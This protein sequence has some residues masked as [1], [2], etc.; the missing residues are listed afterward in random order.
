M[1]MSG[2]AMRMATRHLRHKADAELNLI[3]MIDIL[4]VLVSFLLIYSTE[5]E[6]VQ[7]TR[8]IEIPES[9]VESKPRETVVVM[10]TKDDLYLQGERIASIAEIRAS[11]EPLIR[12]L[13]EALKQPRVIGTRM[14]E[15]DLAGR[16]V[17]VM[18]DKNTPYEVLKKVMA[19]C[20]DAD[21]GR[22]SL[23]LTQKDK[24]LDP[25]VF[26]AR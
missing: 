24:A 8:N 16:E 2:R 23:A 6:V 18:G 15:R 22:I 9:I 1:K 19:T 3:P 11:S 7:N 13:G 20:T 14:A 4:S 12:A 17:T 5:V 26:I 10:L 25:S 21:F